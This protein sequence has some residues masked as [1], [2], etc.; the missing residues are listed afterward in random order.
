LLDL[1]DNRVANSDGEVVISPPQ[2][3]CQDGDDAYLVVAADKGTA[4]FSDIANELSAEYGFWLGDAFASGGSVGYDHKVMGITARGAWEA[5]KRHFGE[6]NIDAQTTDFSVIG[7]GDMSG[8]VFG[9]GM[10]LS[11]HILLLA[12]FDHRHIFLDPDPDAKISFAERRRLFDLPRSSWQDYNPALISA[13]GGVYSRQIKAVPVSEA[14]RRVLGLDS[15][16]TQLSP[17]ELLRAILRAPVDLLYNGGIG[18]Y[19][20]AR[21]ESHTQAGDKANDSIRVNGDELRVKIVAEGGNLGL[22]QR[23]RVEAALAGVLLNTDA[24]DNSAGVDCSDHEVNIKI[25]VDRMISDGILDA[26]HRSTFLAG[27][28][29][30]VSSLVL[31]NNFDQNVLLVNDRQNAV[32][33]GSSHERLMGWL[34]VAAELNRE[35]EGLPSTTQLRARLDRSGRGLTAPELAVLAAYAKIDLARALGESDLADDP[36]FAATLRGYF[37]KPLSSRFYAELDS[38]PLRRE[39]I[40]TILANDMINSGGIT[41]AFRIAEETSATE[42]AAAR[43]F[44]AIREIYGLTPLLETVNGLGATFSTDRW[45]AIHRDIRLLIDRAVCWWI[46]QGFANMPTVDAVDRFNDIGLMRRRI[47]DF[48]QATDL[49]RV[50]QRFERA[51]ASGIPPSA[52]EQ[53]SHL[54]EDFAL[55]EICRISDDIQ[56]PIEMVASVYFAVYS[57][58]RGDSLFERIANLTRRDRWEVLARAALHDDLCSAL[59]EMTT[60]IM[61]S[62]SLPMGKSSTS[63]A[64]SCMHAWEETHSE[65]LRRVMSVLAEVDRHDSDDVGPLWVALRMLRSIVQ[66]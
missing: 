46:N 25:F 55:L 59:K 66:V 12:A 62:P 43:A 60:V 52:A 63:G 34:E 40:S 38:H 10:L 48:L 14:V 37:P 15:R 30:D 5:V 65:P 44:V 9:N 32:A 56:E 20:K 39:I 51:I 2:V 33:D 13:G 8:D 57:R 47:P 18:T 21:T 61:R 64:A 6:L 41:F 7:I 28:T 11:E 49:S 50:R 35:I 4:S 17:P 23:G 1:T 54:A 22:T 26:A 16:I 19:V 42:S 45:C 27:M 53:W 29:D 58:F 31:K 36:W 24:I 3:V